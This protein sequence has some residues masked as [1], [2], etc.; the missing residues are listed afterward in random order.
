M[1]NDLFTVYE[2]KAQCGNSNRE[3]NKF[4]EDNPQYTRWALER[5]NI[6]KFKFPNHMH[7]RFGNTQV[8]KTFQ[9]INEKHRNSDARLKLNPNRERDR[10]PADVQ[11]DRVERG[12]RPS[13]Q[14]ARAGTT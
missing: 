1:L 14:Q 13:R 12:R 9:E 4:L 5:Q 7:D 3:V 8:L 6:S 11:F 10:E 2:L